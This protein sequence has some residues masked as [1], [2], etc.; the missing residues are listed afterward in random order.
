M[1]N[2]TDGWTASAKELSPVA[3]NARLMIGIIGHV[4]EIPRLLPVL[5][6]HFVAG[7]AGAAMFFGHM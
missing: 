3:G 5:R 4:W 2:R 6:R 1:T 7:N